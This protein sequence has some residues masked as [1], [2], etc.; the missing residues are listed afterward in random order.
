MDIIRIYRKGKLLNKSELADRCGINRATLTLIENG[1]GN[2]KLNTLKNIC[3]I[4]GL[5]IIIIPE[6][7]IK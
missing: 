1:K 3:D 4:L 5:K 2:P 7:L 6:D